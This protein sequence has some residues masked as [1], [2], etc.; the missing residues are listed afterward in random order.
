VRLL[1][2][3]RAHVPGLVCCLP[4]QDAQ[5]TYLLHKARQVADDL[6]V[7]GM[8]PPPRPRS[9]AMRRLV[10]DAP[11]YLKVRITLASSSSSHP[12]CCV[13]EVR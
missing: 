11:E 12:S 7:L 3:V 10:E 8:V 4:P 13:P 6:E 2:W 5:R 1:D 9:A